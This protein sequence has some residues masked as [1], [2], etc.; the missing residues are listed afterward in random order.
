MAEGLLSEIDASMQQVV[1]HAA[2]QMFGGGATAGVDAIRWEGMSNGELAT[3]VKLL[4]EGPGASGVTQA[5][6]ALNTIAQNLQQIDQTLH[7]Q[8]Q[9]IGVN[10]QSTASELAQEMTNASAAYSGAAGAAGGANSTGVTNQGDAFSA[11]KNAVPNVSDLQSPPGSSFLDTAGALLT[12]HQ[13]DNAQQVSKNKAARQQAIDAMQGYT[14]NSKAGLSSHQPLP[15]PPGYSVSPAPGGSPAPGQTTT[16][17]GYLPPPPT[18]P[19]GGGVPGAPG[20]PGG[21]APGLPGLPGGPGAPGSPGV[22]GLPGG[23]SSGGFPGLPGEGGIPGLPG[24]PGEGGLTGVGGLG[25]LP[26]VGGLPG[27]LPGIGGVGGAGGT[28]G[29]P[30]VGAPGGGAPGT[31]PLAPGPVSGVGP[32]AGPATT[33]GVAAAAQA[34]AASSAVIEDAAVGAAIVGGTAGA[35]IAGASARPDQLVRSRLAGEDIEE[36]S[37]A[38]QQAARALAELE[39]DEADAAVVSERIGVTADLPPTLLEPAVAGRRPTDD[40]THDSRYGVDADLFSDGRMVVPPVLD[41]SDPTE[42]K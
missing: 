36:G 8:L 30:L 5:A 22:P 23:G 3:A 15:P 4:S 35:G 34:S 18:M 39:G 16:P 13:A 42:S 27:G 25:G 32:T 29:F 9:A 21:G 38:R 6:Q 41:G 31:T 17:A 14:N 19:S 20:A 24:L 12:G 28:P 11:A 33:G 10:W 1:A 7:D 26:G 2:K 37:G 40:E